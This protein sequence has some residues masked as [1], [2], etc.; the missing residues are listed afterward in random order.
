[1]RCEDI[2]VSI[3]GYLD[4]ELT[5]QESQRIEIHL[6]N[7]PE[8]SKTFENL[9]KAQQAAKQLLIEQ[10]SKEE[11]SAMENQIFAKVTRGFGW[12]ILIVWS[13][14]TVVYAAFQYAIAPNEPFIEKILVFGFFLGVALLFLSV[15]YERLRE[16]KTDRYKGVFK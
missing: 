6:Q 4:G 13:V 8:C 5:Q 12:S 7:C 14:V 9:E 15:L 2:E 1:M 10:P 11:W 3:S 16:A